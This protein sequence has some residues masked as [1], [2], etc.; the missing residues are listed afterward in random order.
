MFR[1][2]KQDITKLLTNTTHKFNKNELVYIYINVSEEYG[3]S[4]LIGDQQKNQE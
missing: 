2:S 1:I 4:F 3:R